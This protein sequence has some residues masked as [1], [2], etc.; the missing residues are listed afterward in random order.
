M[1]ILK[2]FRVIFRIVMVISRIK[3]SHGIIFVRGM[4]FFIFRVRLKI[5]FRVRL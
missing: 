2:F 3:I 5:F 4:D 1:V